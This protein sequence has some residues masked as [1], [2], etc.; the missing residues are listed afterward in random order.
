MTCSSMTRMRL[1]ALT[2][3]LALVAIWRA[4]PAATQAEGH[5]MH[6]DAQ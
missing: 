5:T 6:P 4:S 2:A 3:A 1:A